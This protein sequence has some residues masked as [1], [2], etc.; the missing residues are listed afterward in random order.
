MKRLFL[1]LIFLMTGLS[2]Y[3][4]TMTQSIDGESSLLLPLRGVAFGLDIGRTE[5]SISGSNYGKAIDRDNNLPFRN[6]FFG[7]DITVENSGGIGYL[8]RSGDI[9]P[10]GKAAAFVGF[11]VN[12]D[13]ALIRAWKSSSFNDVRVAE[14][15]K[16]ISLTE[17]Y[18]SG[19]L[20]D[21]TTATMMIPDSETRDHVKLEA[22]KELQQAA[23]GLA[24]NMALSKILSNEAHRPEAFV[25][26]FGQLVEIRK[27][28][29]LEALAQVDNSRLLDEALTKFMQSHSV[30]R[31]T[32]FIFGRAEG[33][34][35][36]YYEGPNAS[37]LSNSFSYK[38]FQGFI[39]GLGL[40]LQYGSWWFGAT[41]SYVD[42]DNFNTLGSRTY[43][44][45]TTN[46]SGNQTLTSEKKI[47]AYS[48][49]YAHVERNELNIDLVKE[50]SLSDTSRL[51]TNLYYRGSVFSRNISYLLNES[52][53]GL[54][55]YYLGSK[56][57]FLGGIYLELPDINNSFEKS[58]PQ[59]ISNIRPAYKKLGFGIVT[60]YSL[61]SMPGFGPRTSKKN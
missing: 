39:A 20:Q 11:N 21:I 32:P 57:K 10:A 8:L 5:I 44:L 34:S 16:R 48:G 49:A 6:W 33:R 45:T 30:K 12:N 58:D 28:R 40:N 60:K 1:Y 2:P 7:G 19:L 37:P 23:D 54:G 24:L 29:Y 61:A 46:T 14:L 3:A 52:N 26:T 27:R 43:T 13:K 17:E 36:T 41:Y 18:K 56:S 35:F 42:G 53:I 22:S 4:Q 15:K 38:F 31:F 50:F 55:M 9:V 47:T 25:V 51:L 59:N